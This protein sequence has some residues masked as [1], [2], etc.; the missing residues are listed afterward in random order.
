[1]RTGKISLR[2]YL[3]KINKADR[4]NATTDHRRCD[5]FCSNAETG[6]GTTDAPGSIFLRATTS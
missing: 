1:M 2:G 5:T 6:A 4:A 3:H